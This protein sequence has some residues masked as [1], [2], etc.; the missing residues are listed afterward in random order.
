[1][2]WEAE[3][4]AAKSMCGVLLLERPPLIGRFLEGS[5]RILDPDWSNHLTVLS[6]QKTFNQSRIYC[7]LYFSRAAILYYFVYLF[8][9]I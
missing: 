6:F 8:T 3:Q 1:M 9:H 2:G 7:I 5:V 4:H